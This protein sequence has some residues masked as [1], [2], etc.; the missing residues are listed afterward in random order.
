MKLNTFVDVLNSIPELVKRATMLL[1]CAMIP[2]T[3]GSTPTQTPAQSAKGSTLDVGPGRIAWF[4]IATPNLSASK[5]FYGKLF[6][7][8][9]KPVHGGG[10]TVEINAG[11][12]AIG[13]LRGAEGK[14]S[15]F[16]GVVYV[17]VNDMEA[18]C[19]KAKEFGATIVPGFPFNLPDGVGAIALVIDPGGHPV[20]LYSKKLIQ[21]TGSP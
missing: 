3:A 7:W 15:Q 8:T 20:G 19:Q 18:G 16:N 12:T 5:E 21:V 17:L 11:D 10:A 14:I 1:A 2:G 6:G 13:T 9:F 4:D